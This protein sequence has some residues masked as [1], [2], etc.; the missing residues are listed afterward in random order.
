MPAADAL[1]SANISHLEDLATQPL[2]E[3]LMDVSIPD[4]PVADSIHLSK[5]TGLS[6]PT[7]DF[8]IPDLHQVSSDTPAAE[9]SVMS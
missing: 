5:N 3:E 7:K 6:H 4:S 1:P 2:T 8:V 9:E